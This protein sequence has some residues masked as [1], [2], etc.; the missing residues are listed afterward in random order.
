MSQVLLLLLLAASPEQKEVARR[1][2]A[3]GEIAYNRGEYPLAEAKFRAAAQSDPDLPGPARMLGLT[4]RAEKNCKE[5]ITWFQ[6]Y[7]K[8]QPQGKWAPA[9]KQQIELCRQQLGLPALGNLSPQQGT[10][11]LV[12]STNLDSVTI[13]IDGLLRG[14]T[15]VEPLQVAPGKHTVLLYRQ[16]YVPQTHT[17]DV[18]EG[19]VVDLASDLGRDPTVPADCGEAR[20]A[21][22]RIPLDRGRVRL[23]SEVQRLLVTVDGNPKEVGGDSSFEAPPGIHEVTATAPMETAIT[24]PHQRSPAP[25]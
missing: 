17:V 19:Q 23:V 24:R 5:A 14:V 4:L 21:G 8:L 9:V 3:E 2:F 10:G 18:I 13:K 7:L 22:P 15:P 16:C 11:V 6:A 25:L 1:L 12:V 20:D